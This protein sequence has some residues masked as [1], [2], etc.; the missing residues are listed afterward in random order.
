MLDVL[1]AL[2]AWGPDPMAFLDSRARLAFYRASRDCRLSVVEAS[3]QATVTL[4]MYGG[5]PEAVWQQRL[6]SAEPDLITRGLSQRSTKLVLRS[7]THN[8]AALEHTLKIAPAAGRAVTEL[9]LRAYDYSPQPVPQQADRAAVVHTTHTKWLRDMP[10]AFPH[11]RTLH[12]HHICGCLPDPALMPLLRGLHVT[13][14]GRS[15]DREPPPQFE[16]KLRAKC[17]SIARYVPQL[18][19]LNIDEYKSELHRQDWGRIFSTVSHTLTEFS[20][21]SSWRN[22]Y[23][24]LLVQYAPALKHVA[25]EVWQVF[26]GFSGASWA[27]ERYT[28]TRAQLDLGLAATLPQGPRLTLSA[29]TTKGQ[30]VTFHVT[31]DGAQVGRLREQLYH[32]NDK[33]H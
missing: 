12:L 32:K 10:A 24:P 20:T 6:A 9:V 33:P 5:I 17:V 27:V 18:T 7:P 4:L 31:L 11:L 25:C 15:E 30:S 3:E 2:K 21:S 16:S 13:I 1:D 23:I 26:D 19:S 22:E 8:A 29:Q 28:P 14:R